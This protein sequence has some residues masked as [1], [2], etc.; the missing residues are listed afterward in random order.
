MH[1]FG[2]SD[3]QLIYNVAKR[4]HEKYRY[5]NNMEWP[6]YVS[7]LKAGGNLESVNLLVKLISWMN[8]PWRKMFA[9]DPDLSALSDL[10][11]SLINGKRTLF[12]TQL[13]ITI[14][15]LIRNKELVQLLHKFGLAI[16][17]NDT[18]DLESAWA[19]HENQVSQVCPKELAYMVTLEL[20]LLITM[21][22][23]KLLRWKDIPSYKYDLCP[24]SQVGN[25]CRISRSTKIISTKKQQTEMAASQTSVEAYHTHRRGNPLSHPE[26]IAPYSMMILNSREIDVLLML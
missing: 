17:Y 24:T 21:I 4:F 11:L 12:K 19:Y 1:S 5:S 25:L 14:H 13:A 23:G 3:E 15:G 7:Q 22:L 10:L 26:Y 2:I 8:D 18:I 16:S 9:N 20:L 6:P